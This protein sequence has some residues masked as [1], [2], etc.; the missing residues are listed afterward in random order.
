MT[1]LYNVEAE[2]LVVGFAIVN[3][4]D[5]GR[6]GL[7]AEEFY[8]G[9]NRTLW[10]TI[11]RMIAKG[12]TPDPVTLVDEL[13][14]VS[15]LSECGGAGAV[16]ALIGNYNYVHEA[17]QAAQ[18]VKELAQRRKLLILASDIAKAAHNRG[19]KIETGMF[20]DRLS[21]VGRESGGAEHWRRWLVEL[22]EDIERRMANPGDIWGIATGFGA[23]DTVTGGLQQG[24]SFILSGKPGMG[25]SMWAMQAAEQMAATQPG[26]LYSVEMT[27]LSVARRIASARSN[28]KVSAMKSG[29]VNEQDLISIG[30]CI[31]KLGALPVYMS[32]ASNWTTS[33]LRADLAR[34][35]AQHGIKWFVFDYLLLAGDAVGQDRNERTETISRGMKLIC[36]SLDLAGLIVHSMNKAGMDSSS[37]DM[38]NLSGSGQVSYD[39]DLIAFL[40]PFTP[41]SASDA[42]I[43]EAERK[44]MRTM[45]FAKGR[46]LE[47][48]S[49]YLHIVKLPDYPMFGDYAQ[50]RSR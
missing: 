20:I 9:K 46:E 19:E 8:D 4:A 10:D 40:N 6:L 15:K 42:W 47:N 1:Q 5:Y 35:K 14:K 25:K 11:G 13:E 41:I 37:P 16:V 28:V 43:K 17:E 30:K 21:R 2:N 29:R 48:P 23:F 3:P 44:N 7:D 24:E 49:K 27:G 45:I 50:E 38:S 26:A 33:S 12:I 34:L 32:D 31:D 39:A 18:V 36:K 22:Y